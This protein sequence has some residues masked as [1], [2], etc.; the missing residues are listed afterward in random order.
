MN[1]V[2]AV[3]SESPRPPPVSN[4]VVTIEG[5]DIVLTDDTVRPKEF[6]QRGKFDQILHSHS[7]LVAAVPGTGSFRIVT[8]CSETTVIPT[9]QICEIATAIASKRFPKPASGKIVPISLGFIHEDAVDDTNSRSMKT[10]RETSATSGGLTSTSTLAIATCGTRCR[11]ATR[12]APSLTMNTRKQSS[13]SSR[14]RSSWSR[15]SS[16]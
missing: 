1:K 5:T 8:F 3:V 12:L 10:I 11:L 14:R 7:D 6:V 15:T 2:V 9:R 13:I 16:A 4:C